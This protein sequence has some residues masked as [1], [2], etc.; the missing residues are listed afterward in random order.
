[1]PNEQPRV[2]RPAGRRLVS[3][4][5]FYSYSCRFQDIAA[6]GGAQSQTITIDGDAP[7]DWSMSTYQV[8]VSDGNVTDSSRVVPLATVQISTQDTQRMLNIQAPL[9]NVFGTAD[10]PFVL[11][12]KRRLGIQTRITFDVTNL[13]TANAI[14]DL[15]LTLVGEK[16]FDEVA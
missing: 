8:N 13:D 1:M 11:P 2:T 10:K 16:I 4:N 5:V 12:R 14:A 3:R 7:F 15:W 6:A 9:A